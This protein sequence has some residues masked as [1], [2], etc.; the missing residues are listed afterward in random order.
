MTVSRF[1]LLP[2]LLWPALGASTYVPSAWRAQVPAATRA[3]PNPLP[4]SPA[5]VQAG[6][7]T[8]ARRCAGCHAEDGAGRR[9]RPS[10]RTARIRGET[11]GEIFWILWNGSKGH[12]MPAW[13]QLGDPA[14]WQ[15]VEYIRSMPPAPE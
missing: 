5:N 10:L 14:L 3:L 2:A 6:Q 11:D 15:L 12:G 13:R 8:Y 4:Q 7:Q 9:G 1:L